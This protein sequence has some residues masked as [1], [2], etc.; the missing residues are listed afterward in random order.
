MSSSTKSNT[1]QIVYFNSKHSLTYHCWWSLSLLQTIQHKLCKSS[2]RVS[3][4]MSSVSPTTKPRPILI[5]WS[6]H[7]RPKAAQLFCRGIWSNMTGKWSW[8]MI[9]N[10]FQVFHQVSWFIHHN[11]QQIDIFLQSLFKDETSASNL[12]RDLCCHLFQSRSAPRTE[13]LQRIFAKGTIDPRVLPKWVPNN[14]PTTGSRFK[15][16]TKQIRSAAQLW[17]CCFQTV[18]ELSAVT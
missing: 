6:G 8:Q 4:G 9:F 5:G 15:A 17:Q 14:H 7:R 1:W 18:D 2:L 12:P 16:L 10:V 3:F 11:V 13:N